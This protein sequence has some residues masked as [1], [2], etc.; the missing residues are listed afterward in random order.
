[1]TLGERIYKLRDSLQLSQK[2]FAEKIGVS[3]SSIFYWE[4]GKKEPKL[5]QLEKI[6]DALEIPVTDLLFEKG[7]SV[8]KI[9]DGNSSVYINME[10]IRKG[11]KEFFDSNPHMEKMTPQQIEDVLSFY[12]EI[13]DQIPQQPEPEIMKQ[14]NKLNDAGKQKAVE[15]TT[16]L[17]QMEKYQRDPDA[18]K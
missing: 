5:S 11:A 10:N 8:A 2:E 17:A 6:A 18:K 9:S 1:M 14:Y 12:D 4:S 3:Q 16:D 7:T 15:Y 13:I